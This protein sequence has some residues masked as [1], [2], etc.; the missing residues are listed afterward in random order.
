MKALGVGSFL[1]TN[2]TLYSNSTIVEYA[3]DEDET[4]TR[5]EAETSFF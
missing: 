2:Q 1:H 4:V 5:Q 3:L